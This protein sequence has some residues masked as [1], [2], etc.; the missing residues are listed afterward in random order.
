[1]SGRVE[2]A[3]LLASSRGVKANAYL[4]SSI[5]NEVA[6]LEP[7]AAS[8]LERRLRS[9]AISIR[10]LHRIHR[11]ARTIA[12]LEKSPVLTE[13]HVAEAESLRSARS[14]LIPE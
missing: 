4:S 7:E 5:L 10:G 9:G 3:R 13:P 8:F 12:D 2:S 1:V 14:T 6:P 11:V